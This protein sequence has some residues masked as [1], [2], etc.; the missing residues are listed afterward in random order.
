M[1]TIFAEI[2]LALSDGRRAELRGFGAFSV[3][4]RKPRIGRNP[5]TG[6]SVEVNEKFFINFSLFRGEFNKDNVGVTNV[7]GITNE[8]YEGTKIK[9][10]YSLDKNFNFGLGVLAINENLYFNSKEMDKIT[11]NIGLN[12]NF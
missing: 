4:H 11:F 1:E 2:T 7:W 10:G 5:R 8:D 9:I 3:K 12:Y 6:I